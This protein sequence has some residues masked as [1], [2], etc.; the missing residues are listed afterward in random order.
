MC[1]LDLVY[2]KCGNGK[3]RKLSSKEYVH[4]RECRA[5]ESTL[6]GKTPTFN[7][8]GEELLV[9]IQYVDRSLVNTSRY[10][11]Y[12]QN[13]DIA[14]IYPL[15]HLLRYALSRLTSRVTTSEPELGVMSS[16]NMTL[17]N[18]VVKQFPSVFL[19]PT[20]VFFDTFMFSP[21]TVSRPKL[22]DTARIACRAGFM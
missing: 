3:W 6:V 7:T 8:T 5:S 19:Q 13:P 18:L 15:S 21:L 22:I 14:E 17:S 12:R 20:V 11:I 16:R 4:I 1:L 10:F 2:S 9:V